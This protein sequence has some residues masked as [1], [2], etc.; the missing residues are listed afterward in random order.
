MRICSTISPCNGCYILI[1][2]VQ[3]TATVVHTSHRKKQDSLIITAGTVSRRARNNYCGLTIC[4]QKV[5]VTHFIPGTCRHTPAS[6]LSNRWPD[7]TGRLRILNVMSHAFVR[8]EPEIKSIDQSVAFPGCVI[9]PGGLGN[10]HVFSP[11]FQ[12]QRWFRGLLNA[13]LWISGGIAGIHCVAH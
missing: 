12:A 5:T 7:K 4:K 2:Q 9:A 3:R 8:R 1:R 11:I 13:D 10:V 6:N